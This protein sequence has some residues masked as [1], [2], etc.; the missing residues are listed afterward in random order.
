[1]KILSRGIRLTDYKDLSLSTTQLKRAPIPA[2]VSIPLKQHEGI[3]ALPIVKAGDKVLVGAKIA[4]AQGDFS[5]NLHSSI[6]GIIQAIHE[7]FIQIDSDGKDEWDLAVREEKHWKETPG[8]EILNAIFDAGIVGFGKQ[9]FPTHLKI[10][11]VREAFQNSGS[12]ILILNG[13]ESDAFLTSDYILM[14]NH[15]LEILYGAE[16]LLRASGAKKCVIAIEN[17]KLDAIE[18]LLSKIRG[19]GFN[20]MEVKALPTRYPQGSERELVRCVLG[21]SVQSRIS[22]VHSVATAFA[23]CEAVRFHKPLVERVVT[24]TGHCV[25]EPK[26]LICRIGTPVSDL[27]KACKGFLRDPGK[28]IF[29]GPMS[30]SSVTNLDTPITK[31]TNGIVALAPEFINRGEESP[32][33]RC[34]FCVEVC[35]EELNPEMLIRAVRHQAKSIVREFDIQSCIECGNC[36]FVC[37][38]KIPMADILRE[39]KQLVADEV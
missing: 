38:S 3:P 5:A 27:I 11:G 25:V 20:Q 9:A 10:A 22:L 37:P 28:V 2:Q 15:P 29:G 30:G 1:M 35:P 26:N 23:V 8:E 21:G 19:H 7:E 36:T 32:C 4:V 13:C 18:I 33:I 14:I 12:G 17:N 24:I 16:F 39:G 31:A 34:G 6:S